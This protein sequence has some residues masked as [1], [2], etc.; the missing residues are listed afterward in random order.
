MLL[1]N[2]AD[3]LSI[4]NATRVQPQRAR[5]LAFSRAVTDRQPTRPNPNHQHIR[6]LP[7]L[8]F[9]RSDLARGAALRKRLLQIMVR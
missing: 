8:P 3:V 5:A 6:K 2:R 7:F 4:A 9:Q 1:G